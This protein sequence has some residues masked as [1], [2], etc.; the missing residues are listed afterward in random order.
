MEQQRK[1]KKKIKKI[2]NI[3]W[4]SSVTE[5]SWYTENLLGT[6]NSTKQLGHGFSLYF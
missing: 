3:Y 1:V 6:L 4:I 5:I 2:K